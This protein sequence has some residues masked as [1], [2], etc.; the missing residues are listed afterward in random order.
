MQSM[1]LLFAGL[2]K[3]LN[4]SLGKSG[5][6]SMLKKLMSESFLNFSSKL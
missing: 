2:G 5:M 3:G 6:D 4:S 1:C